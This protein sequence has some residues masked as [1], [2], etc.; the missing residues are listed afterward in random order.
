[1]SESALDGVDTLTCLL[2]ACD[3]L[4]NVIWIDVSESQLAILI[5]LSNCVHETLLTDEESKIVAT[6]DSGDLNLLTE[7]HL[8]GVAHLL[9]M[10]REWPCK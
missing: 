10:K 6:A 2:E 3:D 4:W 1:M 5:V 8:H 7:W 9:P